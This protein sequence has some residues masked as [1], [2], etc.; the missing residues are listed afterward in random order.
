[1]KVGV[2]FALAGLIAVQMVLVAAMPIK[3][4][5]VQNLIPTIKKHIHIL[6]ILHILFNLK[7]K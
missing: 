4:S 5:E 6:H 3:E 7:T 2:I 1:M